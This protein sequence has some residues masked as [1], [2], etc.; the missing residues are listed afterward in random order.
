M[1]DEVIINT[2]ET[3]LKQQVSLI[4]KRMNCVITKLNYYNK[5]E[6]AFFD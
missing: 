4:S 5:R 2:Q 3:S 6:E 1:T